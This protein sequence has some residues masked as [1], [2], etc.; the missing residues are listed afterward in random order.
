MVVG[1]RVE[2]SKATVLC[3]HAMHK[4]ERAPSCWQVSEAAQIGKGSGKKGR[5]AIRLI[6][7]LPPD[8]KVCYNRLWA[9]ATPRRIPRAYEFLPGQEAGASLSGATHSGLE[10]TTVTG[11]P[12]HD[13]ARCGQCFSVSDAPSNG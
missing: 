13:P 2:L 7:A 4:Q 12:R 8:G 9:R 1:R 6:N 3:T 10:A 11:G 5:Q